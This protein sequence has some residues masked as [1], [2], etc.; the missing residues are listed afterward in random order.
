VHCYVNEVNESWECLQVLT[1]FSHEYPAAIFTL[2]MGLEK[3]FTPEAI[4]ADF[5]LLIQS[6]QGFYKPRLTEIVRGKFWE[7]GISKIKLRPYQTN[8]K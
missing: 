3:G 4:K 2:V 7:F 6:M 1:N 8:Q 5:R